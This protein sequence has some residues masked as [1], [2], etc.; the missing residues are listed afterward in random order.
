MS[1]HSFKSVT[2][3]EEV[4]DLITVNIY[5]TVLARFRLGTSPFNADRLRYSLS[6]AN[7]ACPFCP[8]KIENEAH[9]LFDCFV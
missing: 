5:R 9:V 1:H 4:L 7:R 8:D 3:R 6:E 2:G